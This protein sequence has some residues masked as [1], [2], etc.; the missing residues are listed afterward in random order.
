MPERKKGAP[1]RCTFPEKTDT[2]P[3]QFAHKAG[4][5]RVGLSTHP[6]QRFA[7][8]AHGLF[9]VLGQRLDPQGPQATLLFL[10]TGGA[11]G[12]TPATIRRTM[13][14]FSEVSGH[15]P[16][17]NPN[18]WSIT[19]LAQPLIRPAVPLVRARRACYEGT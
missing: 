3:Q 16:Y 11:L 14:S 2:R 10:E 7:A 17:R 15:E 8:H 5:H 12:T 19:F 1:G 18:A 4:G 6:H 13:P 9:V